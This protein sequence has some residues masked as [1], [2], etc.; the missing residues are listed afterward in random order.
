MLIFKRRIYVIILALLFFW[1]QVCLGASAVLSSIELIQDPRGMVMTL[2]AD[3]PFLI[4]SEQK[5]LAKNGNM[6][7][8]ILRCKGIIYGLEGYEFSSFPSNCPIKKILI[9]DKP[10]EN[11]MDI[12]IIASKNILDN[13]VAIKQKNNKSLIL[14][15]KKEFSPFTWKIPMSEK[16]E[17]EENIV[18]QTKQQAGMCKL[19]DISYIYRDKIAVITFSFDNNT[20][21]KYKRG[22]KRIEIVFVNAVKGILPSKVSAP[23]DTQTVIELK[24]IAHGGNMWLG[25]I[26][27]LKRFLNETVLIQPYPNKLV[28]CAATDSLEG[29]FYWSSSKNYMVAYPFTNISPFKADYETIKKKAASDLVETSEKNKTFAI[30]EE[31]PIQTEATKIPQESKIKVEESATSYLAQKE[32]P[33]YVPV[34]LIISKN[35]VNLRS[36]PLIA[37]NIIDRLPL[38]TIV[39][40]TEKKG[41]WLRVQTQNASGWISAQMAVDSASASQELL[42]AIEKFNKDLAEKKKQQEE[43]IAKEKKEVALA[44]QIKTEEKTTK[45]TEIDSALIFLKSQETDTLKAKQTIKT[46]KVIEYHEYGRDPFLPLSR[47][48]ESPVPY[49]E[50]LK[51][52]GIL[53]DETD[54]I[55]LFE[56]PSGKAYAMRENDPV[57]NGYLFRI[58]PDKAL[59]IINELGISRTYALK[60]PKE[61]QQ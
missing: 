38:G 14:L 32:K 45:E 12:T 46:K 60:L 1:V 42:A 48:D 56:D 39:T 4:T 43:K 17:S 49:V 55:A 6:V 40:Q 36:E 20:L 5:I 35:N 29:F 44:Q 23:F 9:S 52:M 33:S 22:D 28:I 8:I 18:K 30:K 41:T 57:K 54:R 16:I 58:Q 26:V 3:A 7:N 50:N 24:Q 21:I 51:L 2:T 61:K 37:D 10:K 15:S 53:Y 25:A 19:I 13:P 47:T 31:R 59:F 11:S 27:S 34:K